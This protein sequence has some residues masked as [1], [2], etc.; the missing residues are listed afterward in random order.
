[1]DDEEDYYRVLC[2]KPGASAKE[3][4]AAYNRLALIY[5]P[6]RRSALDSEEK[7][8]LI[9]E[10]KEVLLD[11]GKRA[12]YDLKRSLK[13]RKEGMAR[14]EHFAESV[15]RVEPQGFKP[16]LWNRIV[17]GGF[18]LMLVGVILLIL[19]GFFFLVSGFLG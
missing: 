2:V 7:M 1:M 18:L 12:E 17:V 4:R 11:D 6:D 8:A 16:S 10:A 5:H 14:D 9:N 15:Q 13:Q 3:I 19:G